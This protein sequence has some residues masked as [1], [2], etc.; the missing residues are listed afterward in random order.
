MTRPEPQP[1]ELF[2][3]DSLTADPA[4]TLP[5]RELFEQLDKLSQAN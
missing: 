1:K 3:S 2:L 5:M 4:L